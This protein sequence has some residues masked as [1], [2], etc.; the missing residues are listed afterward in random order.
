MSPY[1]TL[2]VSIRDRMRAMRLEQLHYIVEVANQKS[3]SKAAKNLYISQ[4]SLS[5]AIAQLESELGLPIFVR[6]QQGVI[7]TASGEQVIAKARNILSE[8]AELKAI[9]TDSAYQAGQ[10]TLKVALPLLLCNELLNR[11]LSVLHERYPALTILPYQSDTYDVLNDLSDHSL[12][13]AIIS[14]G[15]P[16]KEALESQLKERHIFSQ[17]LSKED[18]YLVTSTRSPWA[19]R[20]SIAY[21]ELVG[22]QIATFSDMLKYHQHFIMD[23]PVYLAAASVYLPNKESLLKTLLDDDD[24]VTIFPRIGALT[25]SAVKSGD[26]AAIPITEFPNTQLICLLL[27]AEHALSPYAQAFIQTFTELYRS[28]LAI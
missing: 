23:E 10:N 25:D 3:I 1:A 20:R 12:D 26:L 8:I 7:P 13:L 27:N 22:S 21:P 19:K 6:L 17:V 11:T 2:D 9:T 4:P 14:Y 5:K 18:F 16:E 24:M 15:Q 28:A